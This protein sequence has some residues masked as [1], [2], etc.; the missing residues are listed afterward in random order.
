MQAPTS[1]FMIIEQ[2]HGVDVLR[3]DLL[4][5]GSKS[6]FLPYLIQGAK[7]VVFGGPFCGGAPL[8]L[9]VYGKRM[10]IKVTL[11]YAKRNNL[12][13]NQKKAL[14]NG[15]TIYQVPYGYMTNVQ[16]KA[17]KYCEQTGALFL[18]LGFDV[19]QANEPFIRDMKAIR[20]KQGRY[21][22]VWVACGS[23]MLARC[24]G[25][26]FPDSTIKAVVVGLNSRNKKQ[27]YPSN[28][29]LIDCPY[30]FDKDCKSRPPFP[31]S[32]NYDA[33]AWEQLM[34]HGTRGKRILFWNVL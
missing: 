25:H 12:H 17:K 15:A 4:A 11:F 27:A 1:E 14:E 19:P 20:E 5:G 24:L 13:R 16:S 9:S 18:P 34:I 8:C 22:E 32:E 31:S 29:E 30:T 28:V 10:G 7:E 2:H 3:D 21:D 26:A 23:G 6:R 33:K